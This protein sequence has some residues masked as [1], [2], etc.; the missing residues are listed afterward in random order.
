MPIRKSSTATGRPLGRQSTLNLFTDRDYERALLRNFFERLARVDPEREVRP[1]KPILSL[2]GVGGIG[3]SSLLKK[4]V[5]EL[6]KNLRGLRL[7]SLDL[8]NDRWK[9][10]TPV[11]DFFWHLRCQLQEAKASV[12][13]G[14]RGIETPVFDFLY[15]ALWRAQHPGERFNLNDSVLKELLSTSTEGSNLLADASAKLATGI[16]DVAKA[17]GVVGGLVHLADKGL[18]LLR[19]RDRKGLLSKRG[20][21]P[22]V[23]TIKEMEAALAPVLS[24]DVEEWL[25]ANPSDAICVALDGLE[26]IQSTVL[27]EDIQKSLADWCGPLTDPDATFH[28]RFGCVFLGRNKNRWDDLYDPEWGERIKEHG[29]GGLAEADAR[30]FLQLAAAYHDAREDPVTA[31][32]LRQNAD[33]I[34]AAVREKRSQEEAASFH[35]YYL[36]L[37]YDI[38]YDRGVHF[39]PA[40]LG[41][42]PAELQIRFLRYLQTGD[43]EVFEAF[44]CLA[45]AGSFD[46]TLF[47]YLVRRECIATGLQFPALTGEDYSFVEEIGDTPGTFRFH[48]LMELALIKN[49]FAKEEDRV[50]ACQRIA[51]ILH[52]CT[53]EAAF[54]KLADCTTRH[55]AAYQRGMTIAFDRY[56]DGFLDLQ[57]LHGFFADLEEPHDFKAFVSVRI[58]WWRKLADL[59]TRHQP[60][61]E[62][63]LHALSGLA[64]LL[65]AQGLYGDAEVLQRQIVEALERVPEIDHPKTL[66]SVNNLAS[67]L[68]AKGDL[69]GAEPLYR[70]ALEG[71]ERI[72][73][74]D[75]PDTLTSVNNLA[76]FLQAKGD[77]AGAEPLYR[78]ALASR[79]RVLAPDHP[80]VA[81]SLNNL[82]ELYRNQGQYANAEPLYERALAIRETALGPEHP[83]VATSLNNLALLYYAQGRYT[84]AEPLYQRALMIAEEVRGRSEFRRRSCRKNRR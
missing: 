14:G 64:Q 52:Y 60:D 42:T 50:V 67:L 80:D 1:E 18:G 56:D 45:L 77:L 10:S 54:S 48:R 27:A 11:A 19:N 13:G 22:E 36:D 59:W 31:G 63:L 73:G 26:R 84:E 28:G 35:P 43:R 40:D 9:P 8:D 29:V 81:T 49:Q 74:P 79:D 30:K 6:G 70:R 39:H 7:V 16:S 65:S 5:E 69:E 25:V 61:D 57:A 44:R 83:D 24:A 33:A 51:M 32:N 58:G 21:Y 17:G 2:W 20:F 3:K 62:H 55:L 47:D 68:Q 38:V 23:M 82:A 66:I 78:R 72:L 41:Q 53:A 15:F 76:F 75:H 34:L 46:E 12:A 4:T 37:A 71:C